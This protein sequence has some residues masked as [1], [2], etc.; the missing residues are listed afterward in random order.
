MYGFVL[1]LVEKRHNGKVIVLKTGK[2]QS[3]I[4]GAYEM[5]IEKNKIIIQGADP[6]GVFYGV[7]S[8]I[9][10][11]P[12]IK[13]K[14]L[15]VPQMLV[16]DSARF[17]Y[18]GM[19]LDVARHFFPVETVK[20]YIDLLASYKLNVFH[21]HLTDDQ[22][23][24]IEI[25]KYPLLTQVGAKR[26]GAITGHYP[27][28]GNDNIA[29][30]GFYTQEQIKEVINYATDR[31]VTIIP[32]IEMPGHGSAAIAAY[33]WLSCFPDRMTSIPLNMVSHQS[34]DQ[35]QGG[36][37]VKFVQE[38][39]GV[40]DDVFCAGKETTFS[41]LQDV[42]DEVVTLF[43]SKYIHIG[44]DECP[45]TF[46]K[47]CKQCQKTIATN[48]LK[49]EHELQS[50]LIQRIEKYVN[51]KGRSI[52]GWDEILE[53]GLA[54]NAAVMSWRGE[55][56]GIEAARQKHTVIMTPGS[57]CYFDHSN[58]KNEDSLTIGGLLPVEKVYSYN[59]IPASL[60]A[61]EAKYVIG[62]QAN[63][64]TEYI[65]N[66]AK[67]EYM[68]L[69]RLAAMSEV[70]WTAKEKKNWNEFVPRMRNEFKR[71]D[72]LGLNYCNIFLKENTLAK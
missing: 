46:W 42:L 24:R 59:P 30:E 68:I 51:K 13:S 67:L 32:E 54:P 31:Y 44:G 39:W 36:K 70:L 23:W 18:R 69:P 14:E 22:G 66:T 50:Y 57:H 62:A 35:A 5:R 28:K 53:G 71:Y 1:P 17:E 45:K 20:N 7:Q 52:I 29:S 10:V 11:L 8:L 27:G 64:W 19:H 26:N 63:V 38:T 40:F 65:A 58:A 37:K 34:V 6:E 15:A 48:K 43:P 2:I 72:W 61:T 3:S 9:Q 33:P 25:K 12:F 55:Q 21:W 16:I 60:S 49:D 47:Q 41:F 56:G 4:K